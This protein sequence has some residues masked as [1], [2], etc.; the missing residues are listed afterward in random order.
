M[1]LPELQAGIQKWRRLAGEPAAGHAYVR[2]AELL[3]EADRR[4]EALATLEEGLERGGASHGA[5]LLLG[6]MLLERG[7]DLEGRSHLL[8]LL[9]EDPGNRRALAVLAEQARKGGR[10]EEAVG[11]YE[12]LAALEPGEAVW[13]ELLQEVRAGADSRP[14]PEVFIEASGKEPMPTMTLVDIYLAQG[15]R[16]RALDALRRME[17]ADPE[18][19]DVR[20]KLAEIQGGLSRSPLPGAGDPGRQDPRILAEVR[21]EASRRRAEDKRMFQS[22]VRNLHDGSDQ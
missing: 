21:R 16:D 17:A 1:A 3:L 14:R 5:L 4:D 19:Q 18:R 15:Y 9:G 10:W 6:E 11:L 7:R 8:R 20:D 12:R 13:A 22:W 2:L